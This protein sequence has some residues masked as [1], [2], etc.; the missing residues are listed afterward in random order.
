[1]AISDVMAGQMPA[2]PATP[3]CENARPLENG[4]SANDPQAHINFYIETYGLVAPEADPKVQKAA[5]IFRNL[6]E[7]ADKRGNRLPRM[8]VINNMKSA[9]ARALPDGHIVISAKAVDQCYQDATPEA[10]EARLAFVLGHELGH[11]AEDDF[12][13][14]ETYTSLSADPDRNALKPLFEKDSDAP[15]KPGGQK[16]AFSFSKELRA[17]DRGFFYAATAGYPVTYLLEDASGRTDFFTLWQRRT[18]AADTSV[19]NERY[20]SPEKRAEFIRSRLRTLQQQIAF[21][22]FGVRLA[23]FRRFDDAVYFF[24]EFQKLFPS[25]ETLGNLGYCYLQ[26]A[27]RKMN[28]PYWIPITLDMDTRA[29]VLSL[30]PST[31]RG[32][33]VP[34]A[35]VPLLNT[36]VEYLERAC[37]ADRFYAPARMNLALAY[38][39]LGKIFKARAVI[40]EALAL[41]PDNATVLML[42]A[43]IL[44][45]E[46]ALSDTALTAIKRI[47]AL[48]EDPDAPPWILYNLA[49]LLENRG[50]TG[51]AEQI[52]KRLAPG[53]GGKAPISV[54]KGGATPGHHS[55]VPVSTRKLPPDFPYALP[56]KVG[57]DLLRNTGI[58]FP[59]RDWRKLP[60]NW[61]RQDLAGNIYSKDNKTFVLEMD[62][63]VEM[64]VLSGDGLGSAESLTSKFGNPI[65]EIPASGG[66]LYVYD[67][68]W[69]ALVCGE[70]I[71]EIWIA[72]N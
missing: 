61:Q 26:M 7:V 58:T 72:G 48:A 12:W 24:E 45:E 51:R 9:I 11:M 31:T 23:H 65:R 47:D 57:Q 19:G 46:D 59:L 4:M 16:P 1:M 40:E 28:S 2:S 39:Y 22:K 8:S 20:S 64:I 71:R 53:Q 34:A 41:S 6:L 43:L 38:F 70:T 10:A 27:C 68:S 21:Y 18:G 66:K 69:A 62:G 44:A 32:A 50:R 63:Y 13:Q 42:R 37:Q 67:D 56:V 29:D 30:N 3:I 55:D 14:F 35:A 5:L 15:C 49:V 17:D 60:F 25:R 54:L 36:A 33:A 52:W